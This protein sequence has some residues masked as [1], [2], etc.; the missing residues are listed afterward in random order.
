MVLFPVLA[1]VYGLILGSFFNVLI[2]RLPENLSIIRPASR[3]P[4][5]GA[6]IKPW[7]NIPVLSF[8]LL[9]GKCHACRQPISILYPAVELTTGAA[10]LLL[11]YMY[12]P[13]LTDITWQ[14]VTVLSVRML[15]LLLIIP[16]AV[17]DMRHY[18]IPD[19][20]TLSLLAAGIV[21]AL[22]P[23]V[24]TPLGSLLGIAAGGGVLLAI[25]AIGTLVLKK[26]AMGGGD[27]KMMAAAGALWGAE[28]AL[29]AILFGALLGSVYGVALMAARKINNAHQI[30]FGPFL[31]IGLWVAV[32]TGEAIVNSYLRMLGVT[33]GN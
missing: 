6:T 10:A 30:P 21:V 17:I 15:F 2:C 8:C 14:T 32:L 26:D 31:G 3:C 24:P 28:T 13:T 11:W 5:C 18:I 19:Q 7:H 27:I 33:I 20:F 25:G 9:G 22:L 23:G 29:L 16:I 12:V 4:K 1:V